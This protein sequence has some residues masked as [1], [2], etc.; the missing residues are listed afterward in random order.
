MPG[1]KR[2]V[3]LQPCRA[4]NGAGKSNPGTSPICRPAQFRLIT[5]CREALPQEHGKNR[6]PE[7]FGPASALRR[8]DSPPSVFAGAHLSVIE[9]PVAGNTKVRA[10]ICLTLKKQAR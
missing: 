5:R 9:A 1:L 6:F 2:E 3:A 7:E 4:E 8:H 10:M